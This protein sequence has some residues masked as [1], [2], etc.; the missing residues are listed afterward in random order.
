MRIALAQINPIVGALEY[1]CTKIIHALSVAR[2]QKVELVVFPEM[3][4]CGYPP[5]DLLLLPSFI[6]GVTASL[7]KIIAA[8]QN[9]T[10]I[11]GCVRENPYKGEKDSSTQLHWFKMG[12]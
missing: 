2:E 9:L 7:E 11:V 6:H 4:V 3:A 12:N 8:S 1:N 5:E 10:L